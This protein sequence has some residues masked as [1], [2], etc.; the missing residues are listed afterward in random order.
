MMPSMVDPVTAYQVAAAGYKIGKFAYRE[1]DKRVADYARREGITKAEAWALVRQE[2]S[3]R[4]DT[5]LM[6]AAEYV[7]KHPLKANVVAALVPGGQLILGGMRLR[8][9]ASRRK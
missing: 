9:W 2:A 8:R 3:R 4:G 1:A 5:A 7:E 6:D